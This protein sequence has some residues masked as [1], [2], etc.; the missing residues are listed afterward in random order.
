[1]TRIYSSGKAL[2]TVVDGAHFGEISLL[3]D[4]KRIASIVALEMC[5]VYKLSQKDFRKV[6]EP[7]ANLLRRLD[8]TAS[9]R[10]KIARSE[11]QESTQII[12]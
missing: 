5:E 2:G 4:Q 8:Q 11:I 7:H 1:M 12:T 10:I 9:D 6:I 3:K